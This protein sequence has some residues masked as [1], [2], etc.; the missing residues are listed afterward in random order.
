MIPHPSTNPLLVLLSVFPL[1]YEPNVHSQTQ[2]IESEVAATGNVSA[3]VFMMYFESMGYLTCI[4]I[5]VTYI[6]SQIFQLSSSVWLSHWSSVSSADP[7]FANEHWGYY[8]GIYG[9]CGIGFSLFTVFVVFISAIGSITASQLKRLDSVSRSPIFAHFG[10]TLNGV[11][12]IRAYKA[13]DRFINMF[14]QHLNHN[15]KVLRCR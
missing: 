13:G 10:E 6:F 1:T 8:L 11:S 3:N 9:A 12:T 14:E 7:V 4:A 2:L 15:Q 5:L